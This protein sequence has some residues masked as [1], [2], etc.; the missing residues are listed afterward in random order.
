M[1]KHGTGACN[2]PT[3]CVACVSG[4]R[5]PCCRFFWLGLVYHDDHRVFRR[6]NWKTCRE[7]GRNALARVAAIDDLFGGPGL[8]APPSAPGMELARRADP[9]VD[10]W[11]VR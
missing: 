6:V 11:F 8:G 2:N 5:S 3:G 10:R 9:S 1:P 7:E 4:G